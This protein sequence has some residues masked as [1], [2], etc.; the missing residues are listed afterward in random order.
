MNRKLVYT[1]CAFRQ[2]VTMFMYARF[3]NIMNKSIYTLKTNQCIDDNLDMA[4]QL[5]SYLDIPISTD[6]IERF[7]NIENLRLSDVR[8][9]IMEEY[10]THRLDFNEEMRSKLWQTYPRIKHKSL[11]SIVENIKIVTEEV[12]LPVP[13]IATN[14]FL[15][16][17]EPDN[18]REI[19]KTIPSLNNVDIREL[20]IV[21]PKIM[22]QNASSVRQCI[23][24]I[25]KN[26]ISEEAITKCPEVLTLG[27]ETIKKRL[28][29]LSQVKEFNVLR[30]NP[31]V[32]RLIHYQLKAKSRLE[33]LKQLKHSCIS[34]NLLAASSIAFE[35]F[36]RDGVDRNKGVDIIHFL[37]KSFSKSRAEVRNVL[38]KNQNFYTIS[39]I[40]V[41]SCFDFLIQKEFTKTEIFENLIILIYPVTKVEEKLNILMEWKE[42]NVENH[43]VNFNLIT[44]SQI[45]SLILYFI[46]KEHHFS[47]G[48]IWDLTKTSNKN[49]FTPTSIPEFP[50]NLIKDYRFGKKPSEY[51]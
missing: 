29:E 19:L 45:L 48:G 37:A 41:K 42:K 16:Y 44:N 4:Q 43:G 34:L 28:I 17:A 39:P 51:T 8:A 1:E 50:Q 47:G 9:S 49:D 35:K 6:Q 36:A 7:K 12:N 31:R 15:L 24:E 13:K 3:V 21:R 14:C 23:E 25:K 30:S 20:L 18:I 5:T 40:A 32:L 10:L 11:S 33:Y 27:I 22:M 2:P 26:G 38:L 46:E